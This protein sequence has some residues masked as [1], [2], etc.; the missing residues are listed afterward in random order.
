VVY[1][2]ER[3]TPRAASWS[4]DGRKL[5]QL[6]LVSSLKV[7]ICSAGITCHLNEE[8]TEERAIVILPLALLASVTKTQK[9]SRRD[10]RAAT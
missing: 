7:Q 9:D 5:I 2:D 3:R 10:R 6:R 4:G 8:S 1:R